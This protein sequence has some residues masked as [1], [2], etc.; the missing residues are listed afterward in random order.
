MKK[1][2]LKMSVSIDGFVCGAHGDSSWIFTPSSNDADK[3]T[4]ENV[5]NA[6]A[7]LMGRRSFHDMASAWPTSKEK[8]APPMNE[9]PKVVFTRHGLGKPNKKLEA[10]VRSKRGKQ[11]SPEVWD[12]WLHPQVCAGKLSAE[13]KRLKHGS[14]KPLIA[15]GGGGFARSLIRTGLID[16]YRLLVHPYALGRGMPIFS[17]LKKPVRLTLIESIRFKSGLLALIYRSTKK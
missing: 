1:L 2:I 8:F 3:W 7:H 14:G 11:V 15:H 17:E 12:S 10:D 13:I 5:W 9:I 16:E 6:S 4:L